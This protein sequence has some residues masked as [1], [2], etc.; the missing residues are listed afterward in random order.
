MDQRELVRQE[1][2]HRRALM[3][4]RL[5]TIER[6]MRDSVSVRAQVEDK[7]WVMMGLA[8]ATGIALSQLVP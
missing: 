7:P 8:V 1:I 6:R 3:A 5:E 4:A 2:E